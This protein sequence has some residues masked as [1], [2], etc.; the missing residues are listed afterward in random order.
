MSDI[1]SHMEAEP[2]FVQPSLK[3][4]KGRGAISN[5]QGRYEQ[6]TREAIDDGWGDGDI[7]GTGGRDKAEND[8]PDTGS[9]MENPGHRGACRRP[10]SRNQSPDVPFSV[11]LNP[12]SRMRAWLYLLLRA[13]HPQL[14]RI[15]AR[16]RFREQNLRQG[17]CAGIVRRELAKRPMCRNRSRLASI[18]MHTSPASASLRLTRRVLEVLHEC[19]HPVAL[20]SKSSLI[21]RDIDLLSEWLQDGW[22]WPR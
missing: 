1:D 10:L 13:S 21:E 17:Q 4:K 2:P 3:A 8:E 12:L 18:P 11:S 16:T 20:I 7:I 6:W 14:P 9:D 22:P 15:V 19:E 5:L